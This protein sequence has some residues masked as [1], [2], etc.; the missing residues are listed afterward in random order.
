MLQVSKMRIL[1]KSFAFN[2]FRF[3]KLMPKY[4]FIFFIY[5]FNIFRVLKLPYSFVI[6][7]FVC[8]TNKPQ[9]TIRVILCCFFLT[10]FVYKMLYKFHERRLASSAFWN[11][12]IFPRLFLSSRWQQFCCL[13]GKAIKKTAAF[14]GYS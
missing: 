6:I 5:I 8:I 14:K 11:F 4:I 1:T 13:Y 10:K 2:I 3:L 9:H 12:G 7:P